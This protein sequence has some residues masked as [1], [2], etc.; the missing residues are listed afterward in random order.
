MSDQLRHQEL[1][2]DN[3][4]IHSH[5]RH[6]EKQVKDSGLSIKLGHVGEEHYFIDDQKY[7]IR[8]G[9]FLI[10]N[11]HRS[12]DCY[13][14]SDTPVEAL[15]IYLSDAIIRETA[16]Q[17]SRSQE[18]MLDNP[19][20]CSAEEPPC[21]MEKVYHVCENELG[22]FLAA[23]RPLL[24]AGQLLDFETLFYTLAEKLLRSQQQI[25]RQMQGIGAKRRSTREE[26]Y[27]RL[28]IARQYILE[29]FQKDIQLDEL[30]RKATLSKYHLLRTY[31]EAFGTTPYR[32]VLDLRLE[33]S[34]ALLKDGHALE[35]IAF[36]LGFSDRRSF[37][38]AFKKVFGVAPSV[39]REEM[40]G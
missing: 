9:R 40:G 36:R 32:Q 30:S 5:F 33:A 12:F 16:A 26:L 34:V 37:T 24:V 8:P 6:F 15:C 10:I 13:L 31:K 21:F 11:R 25:E 39:M 20:S 38:K 19:F 17:L 35:D 1:N 7:T 23:I 28:C 4:I 18:E 27:R 22:E 14:K 3:V 2:F 29:N